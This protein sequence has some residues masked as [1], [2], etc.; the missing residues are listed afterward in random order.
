MRCLVCESSSVYEKD[1]VVPTPGHPDVVQNFC[2]PWFRHNPSKHRV[3]FVGFWR[4]NQRQSLQIDFIV[5]MGV[6]GDWFSLARE[7]VGFICCFI[8][9]G[10]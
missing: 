10:A 7:L 6:F 4:A 1:L 3:C 5:P 8:V 9:D 2:F